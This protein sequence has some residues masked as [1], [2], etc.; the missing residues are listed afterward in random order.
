MGVMTYGWIQ[1]VMSY[2]AQRGFVST[3][4]VL[5]ASGLHMP[6]SDAGEFGLAGYYKEW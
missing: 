4:M 1:I 6:M 2:R 5:P 3:L